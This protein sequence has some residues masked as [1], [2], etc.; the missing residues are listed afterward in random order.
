[1]PFELAVRVRWVVSLSGCLNLSVLVF[2]RYLDVLTALVGPCGYTAFVFEPFC[3]E[4]LFG[5][6]LL[7]S[8]IGERGRLCALFFLLDRGVYACEFEKFLVGFGIVDAFYLGKKNRG[9]SA[10]STSFALEASVLCIKPKA[11]MSLDRKSVV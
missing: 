7:H 10:L 4:V 1:M 2:V 8:V 6:V 5:C 3:H 11:G 9:I